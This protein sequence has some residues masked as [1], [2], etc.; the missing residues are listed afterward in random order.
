MRNPLTAR[1]PASPLGVGPHEGPQIR[2]ERRR[3]CE[4][5][6]ILDDEV[7]SFVGLQPL[8]HRCFDSVDCDVTIRGSIDILPRPALVREVE[9]RDVQDAVRCVQDGPAGGQVHLE[10]LNPEGIGNDV[11]YC[12]RR[13]NDEDVSSHRLDELL[14]PFGESSA[15]PRARRSSY[16]VR[17]LNLPPRDCQRGSRD[18]TC[19]QRV[20]A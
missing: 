12:E 3:V 14:F 16:G 13:R 8:I 20:V 2:R 9:R 18:G 17:L 11:T 5:T 19:G 6:L 15:R 4:V 7:Q 10:L 1:R